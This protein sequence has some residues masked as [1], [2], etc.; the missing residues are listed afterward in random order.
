MKEEIKF[1]IF[2]EIIKYEYFHRIADITVKLSNLFDVVRMAETIFESFDNKISIE[3]NVK[4][5]YER[6][7]S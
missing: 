1:E 2:A 3:E 5:F 6:R 4:K 7:T